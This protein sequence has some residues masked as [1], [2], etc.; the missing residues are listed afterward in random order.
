MQ[1][2]WNDVMEIPSARW[3]IWIAVLVIAVL[4]AIYV[5][6]IFRDMA[7]GRESNESSNFISEFERLKNEGKLE[8]HEFAKVKSKISADLVSDPEQ[9]ENDND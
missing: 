8:D 9:Q 2:F 7:F 3:V 6:K 1:E 4:V 5:A